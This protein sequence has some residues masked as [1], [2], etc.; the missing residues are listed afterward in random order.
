MYFDAEATS[1]CLAGALAACTIDAD[2]AL[3]IWA[4]Q[5]QPAMQALGFACMGDAI[6]WNDAAARTRPQVLLRLDAAIQSLQPSQ[7]D[8]SWEYEIERAS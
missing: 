1:W 7:I 2:T 8:E 6:D 5:L 3:G 4:A